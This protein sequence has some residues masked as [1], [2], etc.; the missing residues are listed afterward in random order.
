MK[1]SSILIQ[2]IKDEIL[3]VEDL[4]FYNLELTAENWRYYEYIKKNYMKYFP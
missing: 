2:K 1:Q 4:N 3:N